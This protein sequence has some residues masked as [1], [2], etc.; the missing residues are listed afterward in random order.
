MTE[1]KT[2]GKK[3]S[4]GTVRKTKNSKTGETMVFLQFNKDVQITIKG[5]P[6]SLGTAGCV[7]LTDLKKNEENLNFRL[8]KGWIDE[9]QADSI[10]QYA[11]DKNVA[12][13]IE[14]ELAD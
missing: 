5:E 8:E 4:L 13:Y 2:K 6:V 10:R 3:R 1:T 9:K 14:A 11:S 7:F 12:Y